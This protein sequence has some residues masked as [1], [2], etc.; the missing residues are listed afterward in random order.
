MGVA[1]FSGKAYTVI[2]RLDRR[3]QSGLSILFEQDH[4]QDACATLIVQGPADPFWIP[5][6]RFR[7]GRLRGNDEQ[8]HG[9]VVMPPKLATPGQIWRNF[10]VYGVS[11]IV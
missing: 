5:V 3:I 4:K 9:H 1:T 10:C 2:L 8:E 7:E 11:N 6:P